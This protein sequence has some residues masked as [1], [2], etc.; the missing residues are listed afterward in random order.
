MVSEIEKTAPGIGIG[1]QHLQPSD[2]LTALDARD[3]DV[4]LYPLEDVPARFE[5]RELYGEDFVIAARAGHAWGTRVSMSKYCSAR[6]VL[7]STSGDARGFVDDVIEW[8]GYSR[9]IAMTV[10]F[11]FALAV[12]GDSDSDMIATLPRSI[13]RLHGPRFGITAIEP[14]LPLGLSTV[15]AVVPKAARWATGRSCGFWTSC[16]GW[17]DS[18]RGNPSALA[19]AIRALLSGGKQAF[20]IRGHRNRTWMREGL[21][22]TTGTL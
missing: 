12:V 4:A 10:P 6:H 16:K 1:V 11:M 7:V 5:A 8:H 2:T 19:E 14:P 21:K 20:F 17:R 22:T 9:T 13:V 18:M 15:R 3:I